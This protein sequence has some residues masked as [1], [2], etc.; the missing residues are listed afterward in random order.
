VVRTHHRS[1][2]LA[3]VLT[4][5]ALAVSGLSLTGLAVATSA[6][7]SDGGMFS[8]VNSS[9]NARGLSDYTWNSHLAQV[10]SE[11]AHR[12]ADKHKL[13]HN[14]NL[15]SDVGNYRW[16]GENVGYGPDSSAIEK[17][18]MNSPHHKANILDH[19]YT[20]IGIASVRDD[21]GR[22]WV[23]QVFRQPAGTASAPAKKK[24][25]VHRTAKKPTHHSTVSS[26]TSDAS[27]STPDPKPTPSRSAAAK[28]TP[29]SPEPTLA[30]RVDYV[31][32]SHDM[33]T[34]VDPVA[35]ALAFAVAM[36]AVGG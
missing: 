35:D 17:A 34:S 23:A 7:A 1:R 31:T 6:S 21:K 14:P 2:R 15:A 13:Y 5:A 22:L 32:S 8:S 20:Q 3:A 4:S 29:P 28:A 30:E 16:V 12:M 33:A 25:P 11:Q 10:A 27:T 9:R 26:H 24:A 18:F 36:N 19:D